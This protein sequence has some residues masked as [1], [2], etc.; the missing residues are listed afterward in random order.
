[1]KIIG[2]QNIN[3]KAQNGDQITGKCI[4]VSQPIEKNGEGVK[5]E[6][7]FFS[8]KA[9]AASDP[10]QLGDEVQVFFNQYQKVSMV[11]LI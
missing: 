10:F 1:M 4:Y 9:E 7:Y 8:Q 6:K 2:I 11:K 5:C 3:F